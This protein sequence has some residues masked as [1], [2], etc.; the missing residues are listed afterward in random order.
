MTTKKRASIQRPRS[1]SPRPATMLAANVRATFSADELLEKFVQ[2]SEYEINVVWP[3]RSPV[4]CV[5][6]RVNDVLLEHDHLLQQSHRYA[7]PPPMQGMFAVDWGLTPEVPING[8][9]MIGIVNRRTGANVVVNSVKDQGRK[10]WSG[11]KV[12]DAP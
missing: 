10:E 1:A 8:T 5:Y 3:D 2:D 11:D 12:V 6:L 4:T 9:L 7:L